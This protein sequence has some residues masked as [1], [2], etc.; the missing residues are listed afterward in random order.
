MSLVTKDNCEYGDGGFGD[1][2]PIQKAIS[3]GATSIDVIILRPAKT[4]FNFTPVSNPLQMMFRTNDFM[5]R[6]I[7]KDDIL[8][9]ELSAMTKHVEINYYYTPRVLA[10]H[11]FVFES[12]I[13][14]QWWQEGFDYASQQINR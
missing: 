3:M 14:K 10:E 13:L 2:I 5:S 6:Q 7:G 4:D 11:S 1:L 8:I 9:G 12:N